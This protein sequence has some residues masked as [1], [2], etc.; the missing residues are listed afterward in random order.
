MLSQVNQNVKITYI[1]IY[2]ILIKEMPQTL[3][4]TEL[5]FQRSTAFSAPYMICYCCISRYTSQSYEGIKPLEHHFHYQNIFL[6]SPRK[7]YRLE[8]T[9][10]M[11][12]RLAG[13]NEPMPKL[14]NNFALL[15][16]FSGLWALID[17]IYFVLSQAGVLIDTQRACQSVPLMNL[18]AVPLINSAFMSHS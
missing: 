6:R 8:K 9:S 13:C 15:D 5:P 10:K 2:G 17:L 11:W 1:D 14:L 12:S 3:V 16:I 7:G 18:F 4:Y